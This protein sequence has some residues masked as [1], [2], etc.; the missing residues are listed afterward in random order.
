VS[1]SECQLCAPEAAVQTLLGGLDVA[2]PHL[3]TTVIDR[4]AN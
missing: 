3:V 2:F 1:A 4:A